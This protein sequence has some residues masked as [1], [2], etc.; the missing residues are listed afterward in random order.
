MATKSYKT[1]ILLSALSTI[2]TAQGQSTTSQ[3]YIPTVPTSVISAF[4]PS[5][6][7]SASIYA[8]VIAA[9]PAATTYHIGCAPHDEC[10]W[11]A[12]ANFTVSSGSVYEIYATDFG[13]MSA[14]CSVISFS[15]VC[16]ESQNWKSSQITAVETY[17]AS[18]VSQ[19]AIT[20]TAGLEKLVSATAT[21]TT[22]S[23]G[24]KSSVGSA[25]ETGKKTSAAGYSK[26]VVNLGIL[27]VFFS[28][29]TVSFM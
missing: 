2:G 25:K 21:S 6:E 18:G 20:I 16:H 28:W 27:L 5:A 3:P 15:A 4:I 17:E 7:D 22:A 1:I 24:S 29:I 23:L 26:D 9:N 11:T 13:I 14:K 8:S 12:G 10:G 19:H